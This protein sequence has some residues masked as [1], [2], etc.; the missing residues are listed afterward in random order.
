MNM[1]MLSV[2]VGGALGLLLSGALAFAQSP[3]K[4]LAKPA[5]AAPVT[6][7]RQG[8]ALT[9]LQQRIAQVPLL[10]GEFVQEKQLQGFK[11]PLKSEGRLL[12]ARTHGVIWTTLKPFPSELVLTRDRILSR[13]A[14]GRSR[15]EVDARTQPALRSV[16]AM[17][18]ALMSGDVQALTA[19]FDA[20]P[21]LRADNGWT[22]LL[23]PKPGALAQ[24]FAQITLEG[25]R[26]VRSVLIEERNGDRTRLQFTAL[27]E[28][29]AQL[30]ADEA[31][32][33]D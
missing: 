33:F 21:S 23:T 5:I 29:P 14:D 32:R 10:R 9:Q 27:A 7:V 11:H 6:S 4:P 18:F 15:V 1:L 16:N 20:R 3:V 25:D 12:V 13:Q 31:R 22:L 24:A 19:R 17:L 30:S 28:S 2:R 8:D 26:Y